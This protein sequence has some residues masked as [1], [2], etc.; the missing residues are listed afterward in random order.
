MGVTL[1]AQVEVFYDKTK[2][3]NAHWEVVSSWEFNKDYDLSHILYDSKDMMD[4]RERRTID[5]SHPEDLDDVQCFSV[6]ELLNIPSEDSDHVIMMRFKSLQDSLSVY[7]DF[8]IRVR[9]IFY[10]V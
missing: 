2:Y 9:I 8:P 7:K 1:H 5:I 3:S 10:R 4:Y 6:D